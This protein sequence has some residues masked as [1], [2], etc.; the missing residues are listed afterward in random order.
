MP[1]CQMGCIAMLPD[2]IAAT[3][4]KVTSQACHSA[5][6]LSNKKAESYYYGLHLPQRWHTPQKKKGM[7]KTWK[8][9][10][11]NTQL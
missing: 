6:A 8:L 7:T 2:G 1:G 3:A 9:T 4:G 10:L 11:E 5:T